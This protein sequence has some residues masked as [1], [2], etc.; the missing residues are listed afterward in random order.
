METNKELIQE[1]ILSDLNSEQKAAIVQI[2]NPIRILAGPGSGKTKVLTRKMAYLIEYAGIKP[3]RILA[4]TFTN[5]AANEMKSRVEELIGS[6]KANEMIVSTFHSFCYKFLQEEIKIL[7]DFE[8]KFIVI[9]SVDQDSVLKEIYKTLNVTKASLPF[10]TMKEYI[11]NNKNNYILPQVALKNANLI[12]DETEIIKAKIFQYYQALLLASNSLDYDDL[13]IYTKKILEENESIRDKW[14]NR[15]DYYLIDEFQDTSKIQYEIISL[16]SKKKNNITIVGDPDQTIYSWR[17]ADI[18]FINNFDKYYDNV[19]TVTL[20]RNYRST[21]NILKVANSLIKNNS[22]RIPKTLITDNDDDKEV[23]YY[24]ALSSDSES[25]WVVQQIN[26]LRRENSQLK[27]TVVLYRSNYYSR[28]IEDAFIKAL[29]PYKIINGQKFYEREEIKDS[30]A[31][32]RCISGPTDISLKRIINVPSRKLGETTITKLVDFANE[33]KMNLWDSWNEYF[34]YINISNDK[35]QSLSNFINILKKYNSL[36]DKRES[37]S[38]IIESFLNE[39]GYIEMLNKNN[40]SVSNNKIENINELILSIK[41]WELKNPN[42]YIDDYLDFI[43]LETINNQSTAEDNCVQLMTIH[44]AKG[45]EFENV[46]VIGLNEGVFPSSKILKKDDEEGE[47]SGIEE[48]RRLAFVAFTRAKKRLFLSSSNDSFYNEFRYPSRFIFESG[49]KPNKDMPYVSH[50]EKSNTLEM[51]IHKED[52]DFEP[53]DK[54]HHINFGDGIVLDINGDSIIIEFS[55]K[56]IGVK[57]LLKNHKSIEKV[58]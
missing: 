46:F 43:S 42:K 30:L 26:K 57:Q 19:I 8:K 34:E 55:K 40:D 14:S 9:D 5:K 37:I 4:L 50:F 52:R 27:D 28:S 31:F 39:I 47:S 11:S 12:E 10:F 16:I 20:N 1:K 38:S 22:N 53:G 45:L 41:H 3:Y 15:F 56:G 33:K 54:I 13:L 44:A 35:K 32:L 2:N 18:S 48:E 36:I 6:K 58:Y 23:E 7:P 51:N 21:P 25:L 29:I 49:I 24:N 17:G